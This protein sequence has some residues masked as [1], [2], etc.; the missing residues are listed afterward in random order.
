VSEID[1]SRKI[2]KQKNLLESELAQGDPTTPTPPDNASMIAE[3]RSLARQSAT[4]LINEVC[5]HD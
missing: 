2:G 5:L 4:Y 3:I 1:A